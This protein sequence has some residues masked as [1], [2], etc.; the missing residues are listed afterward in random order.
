[1]KNMV[2]LL[3]NVNIQDI[4][5]ISSF[6]LL[7]LFIGIY[8]S[9]GI[10]NLKEYALGGRNFST[11]T[12][13][14]T[15]VAT[16]M[17]G[18]TV[19]FVAYETHQN[20]LYFIIPCI[21]DGLSFLI[22]AYFLAP[23][24]AEFL[25]N[26][27]IAE[28]MGDMFGTKIRAITALSGMLPAIGTIAM[29]FTILSALLTNFIGMSGFYAVLLSSAVVIIYSTFGGIKA[30]TF[31][32]VVQF[33]TFGVIIPVTAFCI[34]LAIDNNAIVV[35]KVLETHPIFD[36][37]KV[38]DF[39]DARFVSAVFLFLFFLIPSLDPAHFQRVSMARNVKQAMKSLL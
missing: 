12:L 39:K 17:A 4:A 28:A 32:D 35:L 36:F 30:V 2:D 33:F 31:T 19:P 9:R 1:M 15:I 38:L 3:H 18:S 16:W 22:V 27:S 37:S 14:A 23:R 20:G 5:I 21:A 10:A 7:N 34:W 26:L 25:G 6:L 29:Q 11:G 8:F 13:T 24:M